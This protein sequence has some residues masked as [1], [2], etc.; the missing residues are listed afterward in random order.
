[1]VPSAVRWLAEKGAGG[2]AVFRAGGRCYLEKENRRGGWRPGPAGRE[3]GG[4]A[5]PVPRTETAGTG[6][7]VRDLITNAGGLLFVSLGRGDALPLFLVPFVFL[8]THVLPSTLEYP[9][10]LGRE[11]CNEMV[12]LPSC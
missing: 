11:T 12:R 5:V 7:V 9:C 2:R 3:A 10:I 4:G 8:C 6:D 1:V